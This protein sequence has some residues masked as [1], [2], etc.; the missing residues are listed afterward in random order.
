VYFSHNLQNGTPRI[1]LKSI[2]DKWGK[3]HTDVLPVLK[4][5]RIL[6]IKLY[7]NKDSIVNHNSLRIT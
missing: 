4:A 6:E 7:K 2:G 1:C 3:L 5:V